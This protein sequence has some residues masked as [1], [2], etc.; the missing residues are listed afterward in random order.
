[1]SRLFESVN[2]TNEEYYNN[3]NGNKISLNANIDNYLNDLKFKKILTLSFIERQN[4]E[5]L[6]MMEEKRLKFK[7]LPKSNKEKMDN[8][9]LHKNWNWLVKKE[10]PKMNKIYIKYKN[11]LEYNYKKLLT[12]VNKEVKKK[13]AKVQRSQKEYNLRAKKLQREMIV[14]WRK[15]DKEIIEIKK[16]KDKY[17]IEKKKREEELQESIMQKKRLEYLMKQSDI[18]SFFMHQK[19]G[20]AGANNENINEESKQEDENIN[21]IE[22]NE[23]Y[24]ENGYKITRIG[25]NEIAINPKTNKI[26]FQSIKVD[27]DETAA[28]EGVKQMINKQREKV[29]QFDQQIN[30]IRTTLGGE[31]VKSDQVEE[32]KDEDFALEGLDN[33]KLAGTASELLEQPKS[34]LGDL[35]EY[36]LKGLRWLDNLFE[37]GINGILAD[38]MGL[39]KTIQAISLLAHLSEDK[40]I[41]FLKNN[42]I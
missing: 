21:L 40:S 37:Q 1:M 13:A 35:K 4:R 19:L 15:R 6:N 17:E 5:T 9:N 25:D 2:N 8:N 42:S 34:F 30:M 14:F 41:F 29:K 27:I 31:Q 18:Y 23:A 33:P 28:K 38:E 10:I 16:R 12:M 26:I 22:D 20:I 39:G 24:D 11:D 36:Q 32:C 7:H 3:Q